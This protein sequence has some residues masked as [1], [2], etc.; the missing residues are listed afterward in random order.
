MERLRER[1]YA[2]EVHAAGELPRRSVSIGA[3]ACRNARAVG[4]PSAWVAAA[5]QA[6]Y[7][8]K[9]AGRNCGR[10]AKLG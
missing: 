8:A 5:D 7:R 3:C 2:A 4:S 10:M 9:A 6:L 1:I